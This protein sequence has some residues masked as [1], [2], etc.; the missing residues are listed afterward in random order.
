MKLKQ[1]TTSYRKFALLGSDYIFP[2]TAHAIIRNALSTMSG[3]QVNEVLSAECDEQ[4]M[5]PLT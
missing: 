1:V 3:V 5:S 4:V 2:R